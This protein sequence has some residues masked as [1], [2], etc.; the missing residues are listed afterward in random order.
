[1]R[2]SLILLGS[3][4][5]LAASAPGA[6]QTEASLRSFFEGKRIVLKIDM[7]GTSDGVD[8]R[9]DSS[10]PVD[11]QQYGYRLKT[12]GTAIRAGDSATVTLVK[13]KKD[14]IEFQVNGGGFGTF[15]DDTTT[16]VRIPRVEKSER[17]KEL[18]DLVASE[19]DAK[20][21]REL[22]RELSGVRSARERE[23]RRIEAEEIAAEEAKRARVGAERLRG[24]SRFNIRYSNRVPSGVR[25]EEVMAA[26]SEFIDFRTFGWP[27][28]GAE[29][30]SIPRKGMLRADVVELFEREPRIS[31]RREGDFIVTTLVFERGDRTITTEFVEDVLVR[32]TIAT[33]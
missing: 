23:N 32:Y 8:V 1:M 17:E 33:E 19:R 30:D 16:D 13:V 22:Q 15:S 11:Y 25:P 21:R 18:E 10:R 26:L 5:I 31:E 14:L 29:N 28:P 9:A 4:L 6:A 24:G 3:V 12:N 27:S 7:P 2:K 20:I